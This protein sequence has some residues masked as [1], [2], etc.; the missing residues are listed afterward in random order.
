MAQHHAGRGAPPAGG[1]LATGL[2]MRAHARR[3]ACQAARRG[4]G[5]RGGHGLGVAAAAGEG[6]GILLGGVLPVVGTGAY[7]ARSIFSEG[8]GTEIQSRAHGAR[9][10]DSAATG[11]QKVVQMSWQ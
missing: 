10:L 2:C 4:R 8:A 1:T 11:L 6:R 3:P 7:L 5:E 9:H